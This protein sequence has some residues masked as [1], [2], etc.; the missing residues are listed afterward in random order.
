MFVAGP[1]EDGGARA[2][3]LGRGIRWRRACHT[4]AVFATVCFF[5]HSLNYST[6]LLPLLLETPALLLL[7]LRRSTRTRATHTRASLL[8]LLLL[9]VLADAALLC[10]PKRR[11]NAVATTTTPWPQRWRSWTL[12]SCATSCLLANK[13]PLRC[14]LAFACLLC[15]CVLLLACFA[16]ALPALRVRSARPSCG[17]T[18]VLVALSLQGIPTVMKDPSARMVNAVLLAVHRQGCATVAQARR[19]VVDSLSTSEAADGLLA[20]WRDF[21]AGW[22][23]E[24]KRALSHN[25]L[26]DATF[27]HVL[28]LLPAFFAQVRASFFPFLP[29]PC[30]A[31][32]VACFACAR[33]TNE[34][35]PPH[36]AGQRASA[37][38]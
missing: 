7:L 29:F 15:A 28:E 19:F 2:F 21:P 20:G 35:A 13:S 5:A 25:G 18:L 36:C 38:A 27:K 1:L 17:G 10:L 16:C 22:G 11:L 12:A 33:T 24:L 6:C 3:L 26:R 34:H 23:A 30:F 32:R 14:V 31:R 9:S 37:C 4:L 8:L